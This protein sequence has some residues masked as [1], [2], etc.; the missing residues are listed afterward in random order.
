M[1]FTFSW[2]IREPYVR[3]YHELIWGTMMGRSKNC[4]PHVH[5]HTHTKAETSTSSYG[6]CQE[7]Q[8][9]AAK[10]GD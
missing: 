10:S 8:N 2:S 7:E 6:L 5:S 9:T 4:I 3:V 1:Y